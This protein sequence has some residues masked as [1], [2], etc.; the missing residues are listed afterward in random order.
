MKRE[1]LS[2]VVSEDVLLRAVDVYNREPIA[3]PRCT[4]CA[5]KVWPEKQKAY[6][7]CCDV[8]WSLKVVR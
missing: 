5:L 2:I 3:C 8:T 6:C 1:K 4:V 7:G